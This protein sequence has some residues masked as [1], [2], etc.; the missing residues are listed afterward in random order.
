MARPSAGTPAAER[1]SRAPLGRLALVCAGVLCVASQANV[2]GAGA[3]AALA[4]GALAAFAL[5]LR[6]DRDSPHRLFPAGMLSLRR[7]VGKGFWMIF[8]VAMSTTPGSVYIALLLQLLHGVT[9]AKAGYLY[10]AQSL[11]WTGA[12]LVSARLGGTRARGALV[13]GPL[14]IAAGFLG[15]WATIASGPV[16]AIV[17]SVLLVGGGIGTCWA[18]VG[19]IVLGAGRR[20]EGGAIAALIPTTQTFAVSMGAALSGII[21]NAAGLS[22]GAGRP[23]AALAATWLFG[24]FLLSPLAALAI[25]WRLAASARNAASIPRH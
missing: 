8:F 14:M 23:A 6:L 11:A 3:R 19:A 10:A 12:A 15:L 5:M 21:A 13:L 24:T 22:G 1:V 16:A 2:R 25:A 9:P 4:A 17:A 7:D 18:H 20:G